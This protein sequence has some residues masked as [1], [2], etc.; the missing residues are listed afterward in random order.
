ENDR[1][2]IFTRKILREKL[3]WTIFIKIPDSDFSEQH[4]LLIHA[5]RIGLTG[6]LIITTSLIVI[7]FIR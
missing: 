1:Y 2:Q 7:I 6:V 5:L 3:E 4:I